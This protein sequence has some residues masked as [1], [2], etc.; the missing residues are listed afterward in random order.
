MYCKSTDDKKEINWEQNTDFRKGAQ[1]MVKELK[2]EMVGHLYRHFKGGIYKVVDIA[3]H[4]ESA[5]PL[6]IYKNSDNESWARPLNM[7]VGPVD[8]DKYPDVKQELRFQRVK[9]NEI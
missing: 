2:K 9:I 7:F 4:S 1:N 3:I 6:V 5:E 8:H